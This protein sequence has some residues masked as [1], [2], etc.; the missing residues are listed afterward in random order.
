MSSLSPEDDLANGHCCPRRLKMAKG[1]EREG[2]VGGWG[3]GVEER[4][5]GDFRRS[6][7]VVV[8]SFGLCGLQIISAAAETFPLF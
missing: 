7:S 4:G 1:E 8:G 3:V 2:A 5:K 6:Q